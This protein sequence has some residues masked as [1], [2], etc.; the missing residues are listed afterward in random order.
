MKS[1][2]FSVLLVFSL[3]Y[4]TAQSEYFE[5]N[6]I[7]SDHGN[8]MFPI[9][10]S[11][12]NPKVADRINQ[13]L[14]LTILRRSYNLSDKDVFS[15]LMNENGYGTI[16]L[17]Y[18]ILANNKAYLS[19]EF[20]DETQAAYPDYHTYYMTFNSSNGDVI[21]QQELFTENGWDHLND[22]VSKKFNELIKSQFIESINF[23]ESL[24][25][26]E[27]EQAAKVAFDLTE[28]NATH[29]IWKM[30]LTNSHLTLGK[31]VCYPHGMRALDITWSTSLSVDKLYK[32]HLTEYGYK[33]LKLKEPVNTIDYS[34]KENHLYLAGKIAN[35]YPFVMR[36]DLY[37]NS[38]NGYYWYTKFGD[39]IEVEGTMKNEKL[40]INESNGMFKIDLSTNIPNGKWFGSNG[41]EY[42]IT[43]DSH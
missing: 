1:T 5:V 24:S 6:E 16:S 7:T 36:L 25:K 38:V 21:D 29:D 20:N 18:T 32:S 26:S 9:F 30:G 41:Q 23:E 39:I 22:E 35:K 42:T 4:V 17:A 37:N 27:I 33:L 31:D 3:N 11:K 14:Q 15:D 12:T 8:Y 28:C 2:F 13:Y 40:T 19:I 10:D 34:R 43:F